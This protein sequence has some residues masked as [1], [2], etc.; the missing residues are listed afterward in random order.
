MWRR[1][2]RVRPSWW[3]LL[4]RRPANLGR[5]GEWLAL[6][7]LRAMGWDIIARNWQGWSGEVD[8]IAYHESFLVFVEV[9][10]RAHPSRM[11]P[12]ENV[13]PEKEQKLEELAFEFLLRYDVAD[14]A[15]RLDV[16]AIETSNMSDFTLR[17]Y[18]G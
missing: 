12:E 17:H 3:T 15:F 13:G 18:L 16:I 9:K 7:H 1:S 2:G 6:K 5:W 4:S 10:T 8:L 14:L 11:P